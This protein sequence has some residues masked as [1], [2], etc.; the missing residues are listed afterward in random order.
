MKTLDELIKTNQITAKGVSSGQSFSGM[1]DLTTSNDP[2][3]LILD[4]VK[5]KENSLWLFGSGKVSVR[6]FG[7]R[8]LLEQLEEKLNEYIGQSWDSIK[9]VEVKI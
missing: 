3:K 5:M 6:L 2:N 7:D 9:Q 4:R 1:D 8:K